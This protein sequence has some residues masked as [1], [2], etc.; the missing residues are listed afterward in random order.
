[1]NTKQ[2]ILASASPRRAE[3]LRQIGL[4][5]LTLPTDIDETA[6]PGET[7]GDYVERL[8]V[9]KAQAANCPQA[10][11][12]GSDTCVVAPNGEMPRP[13]TPPIADLL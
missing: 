4:Q 8:A 12:I 13:T 9:E 1:M 7:A 5:F 11:V 2:L 6:K 10:I 3:L